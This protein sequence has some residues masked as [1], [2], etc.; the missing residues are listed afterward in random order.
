MKT[1]LKLDRQ[2]KERGKDTK[3]PKVAT[4]CHSRLDGRNQPTH[5]THTHSMVVDMISQEKSNQ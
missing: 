3:S 2:S 1:K 4:V 5:S